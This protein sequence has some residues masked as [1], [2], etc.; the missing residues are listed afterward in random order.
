MERER[1]HASIIK[2]PE[3]AAMLRKVRW[4][5]G[6]AP[7]EHSITA[8]AMSIGLSVLAADPALY[9]DTNNEEK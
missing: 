8:R 6:G 2:T 7:K 4:H 9:I 1:I 5:F 3:V